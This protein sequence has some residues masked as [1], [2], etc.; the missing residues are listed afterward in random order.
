MKPF[1]IS[2][3][4]DVIDAPVA[5]VYNIVTD[6]KNF[7]WRKEVENIELLED[8]FIE[9]YKGGGHTFFKNIQKKE[10]EYYAFTVQHKLFNGE[11]EGK[12]ESYNGGTKVCFQEKI[13]IK[14]FFLRLIAPLFWN[15]KRIQQ[16]YIITLKTEVYGN[17]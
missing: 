10:N 15:L 5:L 17:K 9:Y 11:W 6:N 12:F 3:V 2:I 16:N 1:L 8:G 7:Q 14:N 4:T 13:Y